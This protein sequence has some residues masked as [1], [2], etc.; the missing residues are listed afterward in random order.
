MFPFILYCFVLF[1]FFMFIS[2]IYFYV[3]VFE[4]MSAGSYKFTIN[5][6]RTSFTYPSSTSVVVSEPASMH[7]ENTI[8]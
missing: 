6:P 7:I 4:G 3:K 5:T 8:Y 2:F 1:T